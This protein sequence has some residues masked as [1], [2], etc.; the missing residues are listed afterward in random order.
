M[1]IETETINTRFII[2]AKS[3]VFSILHN[4]R[5]L[6]P[7]VSSS[8]STSTRILTTSTIMMSFTTTTSLAPYP[9]SDIIGPIEGLAPCSVSLYFNFTASY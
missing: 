2:L 4:G 6:P 8:L 9:P 1:V 7:P 5:R 3:E